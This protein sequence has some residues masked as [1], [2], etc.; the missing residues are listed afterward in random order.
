MYDVSICFM[1]VYFPDSAEFF[2]KLSDIATQY[3]S[4]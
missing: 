2:K 1:I 3:P 4:L